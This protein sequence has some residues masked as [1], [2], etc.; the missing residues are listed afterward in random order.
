MVRLV[1][2]AVLSLSFASAQ[3]SSGTITGLVRDSSQAA[4]PGVNLRLV[5]ADT[6]VTYS[7]STNNTGEYT[8]PLLPP[9]KYALT[10]EAQGFQR[11]IVERI[12][13]RFGEARG[14]LRDRFVARFR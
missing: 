13:S 2:L 11:G 9:G 7:S 1:L 6:G 3:S 12:G 14:N 5:N 10:A 4:L 8:V